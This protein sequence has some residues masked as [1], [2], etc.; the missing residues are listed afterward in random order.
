MKNSLFILKTFS[1][2]TRGSGRAI[3][4]PSARVSARVV[5]A[6]VPTKNMGSSM[7]LDATPLQVATIRGDLTP[8][9]AECP[10][11]EPALLSRSRQIVAPHQVRAVS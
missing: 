10:M 1:Y 9:A 3:S 11:F 8:V 7:S 4:G 5:T 6:R 2:G